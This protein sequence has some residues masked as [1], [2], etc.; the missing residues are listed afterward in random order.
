MGRI[1]DALEATFTDITVGAD[2]TC[3]NLIATGDVTADTFT[4]TAPATIAG[5][6]DDTDL[7]TV[8]PVIVALLAALEALGL[9]VDSTTVV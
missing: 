6:M 1:L 5:A 7:T 3:A 9:I 2:V 8:V 4:P